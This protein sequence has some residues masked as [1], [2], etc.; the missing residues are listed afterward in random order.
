MYLVVARLFAHT[1]ASNHNF[2]RH[3]LKTPNTIN[4]VL[5]FRMLLYD[6]VERD[7][8]SSGVVC[9]SQLLVLVERVYK[10]L[11]NRGEATSIVRQI[12]FVKSR[13][14]PHVSV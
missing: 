1:E 13:L 10:E 3:V 2:Q 7:G 6:V 8:C 12:W 11:H 5:S 14:P 9:I 4:D